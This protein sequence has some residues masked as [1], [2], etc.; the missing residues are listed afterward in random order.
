MGHW[1]IL[2]SCLYKRMNM[3]KFPVYSQGERRFAKVAR[4]LGFSQ[5]DCS[6]PTGRYHHG[7]V[8]ACK[9]VNTGSR[10]KK[11]HLTLTIIFTLFVFR[12]ISNI[13]QRTP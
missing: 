13:I 4:T 6:E 7:F 9:H 1:L 3:L 5:T 2:Q 10:K 12:S 8:V 11:P